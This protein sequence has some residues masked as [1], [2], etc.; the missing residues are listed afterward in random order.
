MFEEEFGGFG[1]EFEGESK[2]GNFYVDSVSEFQ[3]LTRFLPLEEVGISFSG[4]IKVDEQTSV[5]TDKQIKIDTPEE[6]T[7]TYLKVMEMRELTEAERMNVSKAKLFFK[8]YFK[9]FL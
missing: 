1:F 6:T 4:E 3:M 7:K 8:K 9:Q 2:D 5:I